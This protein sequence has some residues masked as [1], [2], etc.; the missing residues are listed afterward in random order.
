MVGMPDGRVLVVGGDGAN[1][2]AGASILDLEGGAIIRVEALLAPRSYAVV[3]P[4]GNER[5]AVIG[6]RSGIWFSEL[7]T[8]ELVD[9]A[10]TSR[11]GPDLSVQRA[12]ATAHSLGDDRVIVMGG[13]AWAQGVGSTWHST[14]EIVDFRRGIVEPGPETPAPAGPKSTAELRDGRLLT[15]VGWRVRRR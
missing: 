1:A 8:T 14:T 13:S 2:T 5:V 11:A 10:G 7:Q 15:C 9:L 6:G 12:N 4:L 3:A